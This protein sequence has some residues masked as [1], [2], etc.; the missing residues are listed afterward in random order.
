M[1]NRVRKKRRRG[2]IPY[3]MVFA[4]LLCLIA[5]IAHTVK[6]GSAPSAP[7]KLLRGRAF[8]EDGA[9]AFETG[10]QRAMDPGSRGGKETM[11][12]E[13]PFISQGEN[14][15]TGCESVC[16]VM[17]LQYFGVDI[18]VDEFIDGYLPL[19][20][21]PHEQDGMLVGCDPREAF[22][23]DPRSKLGWGCYSQVIFR[24]LEQLLCEREVS[25]L[26][27]KDLSGESLEALCGEYVASGVPV[28]LWA[29]IDM[30]GPQDDVIFFT[31][32]TG[33]EFQWI[34][35][36]HCL[37]LTGWDSGGYFFNDPLSGR[38][39]RYSALSVERAYSGLGKQALAVLPA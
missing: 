15:P 10:P 23:G 25:F 2:Y 26:S 33:E 14:W 32:D 17:A 7:G 39:V 4:G 35:P 8:S 21:A 6:T 11:L 28:L 29:T 36:M 1:K 37:L 24:A 12:L 9:G 13:V 30:E 34:Y 18:G 31:E 27:V 16:T 38:D 5:L 3:F 22:P 20:N 19:G